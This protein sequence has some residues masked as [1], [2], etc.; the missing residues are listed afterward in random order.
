MYIKKL[1]IENLRTI[2]EETIEFPTPPLPGSKQAAPPGPRQNVTV[3]LGN[4]GAGKTTV[5]RAVALA[6][7]NYELSGGSGFVPYSLVRRVGETAQDHAMVRGD[8]AL[9]KK[10]DVRKK[11]IEHRILLQPGTAFSDRVLL[12]SFGS[13][14]SWL[15][16]IRDDHSPAALVVGYGADRRIDDQTLSD[17]EA[18]YKRR[19]VRYSRIAGLFEESVALVPL[20][21]WL[22]RFA[23]ENPGRHKQVI[24]LINKVL[25]DVSI[26]PKPE[27][28]TYRFLARGSRLPFSALSDGYRAFIGWFAD[29]LYHICLGAPKG[30]RLDETTGIALV[31]EVD[32]HLHPAWQREVVARVADAL[33]HMQFIFTTHSPLVVGALHAE[34]VLVLSDVDVG[35]GV[36]ETRVD[37]PSAETFGL[38]ADQLLTSEAFGLESTRNPDFVEKLQA[39]SR[40][41]Q[42]G[43]AEATMKFLRM[44][45]LGEAGIET[46]RAPRKTQGS[47]SVRAKKP[48]ARGAAGKKVAPKTTPASRQAQGTTARKAP[49]KRSARKGRA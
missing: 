26:E 33:P 15:G 25:P 10:Q 16:I 22:P 49:A 21:S 30:H 2:R 46:P 18:R 32:L 4:N 11:D 43:D 35:G 42:S 12:A 14:G 23:T 47:A 39:V 3:L 24:S 28:G 37:R 29:L 36:R 6:A 13:D 27:E 1:T 44:A 48:T 41:A 17:L 31:D 5:L 40:Q 19:T 8:F 45:A 20:G 7:M 38:G 9:Y 34:N